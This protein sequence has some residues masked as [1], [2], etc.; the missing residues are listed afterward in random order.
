MS[1]MVNRVITGLVAVL[2][3]LS[4]VACQG[5]LSS[6]VDASTQCAAMVATDG[7]IADRISE[8]TSA[9]YAGRYNECMAR[10]SNAVDCDIRAVEASH[11]A[12][13]DVAAALGL[14]LSAPSEGGDLE[15]HASGNAVT[16]SGACPAFTSD[17]IAAALC[18]SV[19]K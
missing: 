11:K 17:E 4:S 3:S 9:V 10:S 5:Q 13:A 15:Y 16:C 6:G 2:L 7:S 18:G 1:H 19:S 14:T 8:V 12:T